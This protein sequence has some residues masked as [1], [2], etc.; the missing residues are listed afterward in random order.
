MGKE[1]DKMDSKEQ[2]NKLDN[3][4]E[5]AEFLT[6]QPKEELVELILG[7][8]KENDPD[9]GSE[10]EE[11]IENKNLQN[12][13][14]PKDGKNK[15]GNKKKKKK[16]KKIVLV[17]MKGFKRDFIKKPRKTVQDV[18]KI[19]NDLRCFQEDAV[20]DAGELLE[21]TQVSLTTAKEISE[22]AVQLAKIVNEVTDKFIFVNKFFEVGVSA[23][24]PFMHIIRIIGEQLL[25]L[26][27]AIMEFGSEK[28][29]LIFGERHN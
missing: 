20:E 26:V 4:K 16:R 24:T 28:K 23:V 12:E 21:Q 8:L 19:L 2:D 18:K 9:L 22:L 17:D 1:K 15:D 10:S 6:K 27:N 5:A 29:K 13:K 11:E 3:Y 25:G 14:Q 7:V